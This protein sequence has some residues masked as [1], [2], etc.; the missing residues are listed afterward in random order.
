MPVLT[1]SICYLVYCS[2]E[3]IMSLR[4]LDYDISQIVSGLVFG[5]N[6]LMYSLSTILIPFIV[7]KWI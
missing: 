5:I 1:G 2:Q 4:L 7:P 6:P 3:P